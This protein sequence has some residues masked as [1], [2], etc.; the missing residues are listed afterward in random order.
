MSF[1]DA[2]KQWVVLNA[3]N[4]IWTALVLG[5]VLVTDLLMKL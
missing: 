1:S 5:G 3:N 4:L 2:W